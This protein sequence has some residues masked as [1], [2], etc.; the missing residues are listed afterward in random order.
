MFC[1]DKPWLESYDKH[2][3]GCIDIPETTLTDL[4]E[5][6]CQDFPGNTAIHYLGAQITF[7]ELHEQSGKLAAGL[8]KI[9]CGQGDVVAI[10]LPNT[11]QYLISIFG[12]LRAGCSVSGL[13]P[14][15]MPDEMAYQLNDSGAKA[16]IIL[17][18]LLEAKLLPAAARL[19]KLKDVLVTG[20]LDAL[21][22]VEEYPQ[23][24]AIPGITVHRYYPFLND[25]PN[26][27]PEITT[28]PRDICFLQYTG[29][30]TG[31]SKGAMLSHG[32]MASNIAQWAAWGDIGRG[33]ETFLS[34]FPMFHSAGLFVG[35]ASLSTGASQCVIP[36]PRNTDH[37]VG[38]IAQNK[39][40]LVGNVPS[41]YM[42]LM[43][44]PKFADLD[45]SSVKQCISGAAPIPA[46]ALNKLEGFVGKNK[47]V[48]VWGMTETCPFITINPVKGPKKAGSVGLPIPNTKLR[49]VDLADGWTEMPVNQ[50][51]E[52]ICCG[53]QVMQGYLNRPEET[54]NALREHEGEIWMHT[55]DVGRMDDDGFVYVV[56]RAKDMIIVGG[57]K[58]F[59]SEVED[60]LYQHPAIEMCALVGLPNPERPDS[61]IVKLF[62]QKSAEYADVP[63]E[64]V[65]EE[66]A[67][68]AKEKLAPYKAPKVYEFVEAIPLTSVGKVNKKILRV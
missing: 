40:T 46:Q 38:E 37:I 22:A 31:P 30:A 24:Q 64:K 15:L 48:E 55:G 49:V 43:E 66:I 18:L 17:D 5:K 67:A 2:V 1:E 34:G 62:V 63:D 3:E 61:E 56:D 16:L 32:A 52:L 44:N 29:G 51:G 50:E 58:V 42:M 68:F 19:E 53:P 47:I 4:I 54:L 10:C 20:A 41:L 39:P 12:A 65:Q 25:S 9:G 27:P 60:K 11:P 23:G 45:F 21:P 35:V 36:D 33:V 26:K 59:S 6:A 8:K 28:T 7:K 13:A 14:L 57:F